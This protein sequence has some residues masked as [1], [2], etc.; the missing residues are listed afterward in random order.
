M[1]VMIEVLVVSDLMVVVWRDRVLVAIVVISHVNVIA[2][3]IVLHLN[4]L[5]VHVTVGI[6]T[7]L[8][9][10]AFVSLKQISELHFAVWRIVSSLP[11]LPFLLGEYL[12]YAEL[13]CSHLFNTNC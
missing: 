11:L 5:L 2:A 13:G 7:I 9:F 3:I 1:R 6:V 12:V 10:L 4:H 8:H